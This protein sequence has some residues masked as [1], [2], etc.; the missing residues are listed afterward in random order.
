MGLSAED[1]AALSARA[2]IHMQPWSASAFAGTLEQPAS[3]LVSEAGGFVLGL[4]VLDEAEILALATDP[5]QQRQGL[6]RRLLQAFEVAAQARGAETVFLEVA[7]AN[8]PAQAF[9]SACGYTL[10]GRRKG[11]YRH[12]DGSR[13]D[14][15]LMR[16]ALT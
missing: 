2:Y 5:A 15:L 11:Y 4:V 3:L 10:S 6:G 12:A 7:A 16:R 13:D 8:I 9:Y 14:A 1:L